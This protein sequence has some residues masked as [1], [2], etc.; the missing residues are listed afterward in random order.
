LE[1]LLLKP[2]SQAAL[3]QFASPKIQLEHPKT[4]PPANLIACF[5]DDL[6]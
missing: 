5:H 3:A 6:R 4:E 2:D 1:G